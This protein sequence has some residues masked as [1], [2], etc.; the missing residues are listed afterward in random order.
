MRLLASRSFAESSDTEPDFTPS[1]VSAIFIRRG[2]AA[3]ET[4]KSLAIC[5]ID[6]SPLRATAT[7]SRRNS[8]G[9]GL[10]VMNI[11]PP[12]R[13]KSSQAKCQSNLQQSRQLSSST[14]HLPHHQPHIDHH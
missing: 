6:A 10:G 2:R 11:L 7:T 12:A 3:G 4:P 14:L 1:S 13:I 9:K 5:V 8:S